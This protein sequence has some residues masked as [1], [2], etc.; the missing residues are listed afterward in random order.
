MTMTMAEMI[1]LNTATTPGAP[2]EPTALI[3]RLR[4][5]ALDAK[6]TGNHKKYAALVEIEVALYELNLKL[7]EAR[8]HLTG[9]D[10]L[11][12]LSEF[13]VALNARGET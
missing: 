8:Y 13:V 2:I 4:L 7:R 6:T 12:I 9:S 10:R 1:D 3:E 5:K 11:S